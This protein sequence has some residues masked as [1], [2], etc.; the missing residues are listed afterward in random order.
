MKIAFTATSRMAHYIDL[1]RLSGLYGDTPD[2]IV[3][4][5]VAERLQQLVIKGLH[6][7]LLDPPEPSRG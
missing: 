6:R 1:L 5:L 2:E 7:K 3:K 4:R